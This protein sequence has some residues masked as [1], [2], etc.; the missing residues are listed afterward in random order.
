MDAG[1]T[2]PEELAALTEA[3][4]G[5]WGL[6]HARRLLH[7]IRILGAGVPHDPEV[8]T[9]AVWLHD[10]GAYPAWALPGVDHAARSGEVAA[11]VLAERGCPPALCGR[12]AA[13]VALHHSA[14][15][16]DAPEAV[17]LCDADALDFLGTIGVLREFSRRPKDLRLAFEAIRQRRERL[18]GRLVLPAA[19]KLAEAR[20]AAMDSLLGTFEAESFG[21][22]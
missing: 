13:C 3:H 10:W 14:G 18:P 19:R 6:N 8:V 1:R 11:R 22:F 2:L 15:A 16:G 7:L 9:L 20:V 4:G 21:C 12:V 17:L 5:A